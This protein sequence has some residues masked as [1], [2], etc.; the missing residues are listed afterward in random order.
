MQR[1]E[2]SGAVRLI[3]KSL[4]VKGLM[5]CEISGQIL[6][7]IKILSF[8]KI[9]LVEARSC[10]GDELTDRHA[11]ANS[12]FSLTCIRMEGAS[13]KRQNSE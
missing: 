3:Y 9:R 4:G 10:Y 13:G 8:M 7:G 5:K 11:V 12:S 6:K 2:V 1:L